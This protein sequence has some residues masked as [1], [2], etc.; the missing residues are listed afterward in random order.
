[1]HDPFIRGRPV[2][3]GAP[4]RSQAPSDNAEQTSAKKIRSLARRANRM[5]TNVTFSSA[6]EF[7]PLADNDCILSIKNAA[8]FVAKL[9]NMPALQ[10]G[11]EL[12]QRGLGCGDFREKA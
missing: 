3:Y 1:M 8:W 10:L 5:R 12:C 9:R 6:E 7:V 4:P 2:R 11:D